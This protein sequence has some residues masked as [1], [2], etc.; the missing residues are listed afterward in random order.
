MI[1]E[2]TYHYGDQVTIPADP[3]APEGFEF[4]GWDKEVTDCQGNATYT[5]T[6]EKAYIPGDVDGNETVTDAD[7]VY[8]LYYTF[9]PDAYPVNQDCDFNGDGVVTDQDAVYLLY[10]TFLPD[11]YPIH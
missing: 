5:A 4:T 3:A 6:F 7:A 9:L 2:K 11:Q 1:A 8:L 10:Y